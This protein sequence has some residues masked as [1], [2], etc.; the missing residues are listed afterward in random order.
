MLSSK[1]KYPLW[2]NILDKIMALFMVV[3]LMPVFIFFFILISIDTQSSGIFAQKRVGQFGHIFTIYKFKSIH[4][5]SR[6]ISKLGSFIRRTKIDELPQLFNIL[7]GDMSFV[8][9]R[10]DV[11]GYYDLLKGEDREV[12]WLKPG[13]TS[14]ASIKYRNEDQW[15]NSSEDPELL[16]DQILFPDKVKMNRKYM[17]KMSLKTD[18]NIIFKTISIIF[19]NH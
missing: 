6:R 3:L 18:L 5:S 2:K 11:P 13:L 9:P 17:H 10:P 8:G 15:L 14:E 4:A 7:K 19:A 12:L 16:N 1:R